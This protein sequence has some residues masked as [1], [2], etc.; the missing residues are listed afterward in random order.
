MSGTIV[1][2]TPRA[3]AI[4]AASICEILDDNPTH[5]S[6]TLYCALLAQAS[7]QVSQLT[8][9]KQLGCSAQVICWRLQLIEL[10]ACAEHYLGT[11]SRHSLERAI[12]NQLARVHP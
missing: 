1:C 11:Y 7:R 12:R 9:A 10:L 6:V 4:P 8:M 2:T 3:A 5:A